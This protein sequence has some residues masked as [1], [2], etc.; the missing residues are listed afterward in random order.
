MWLGI[1]QKEGRTRISIDSLIPQKSQA[2]QCPSVPSV[3]RGCLSHT[4]L[5]KAKCSLAEGWP[6][7]LPLLCSRRERGSSPRCP[8]NRWH[9]ANFQNN[10]CL[11]A[12]AANGDKK[13]AQRSSCSGENIP[14]SYLCRVAICDAASTS[15]RR[16]AV[17]TQCSCKHRVW[18]LLT[19]SI[20][21]STRYSND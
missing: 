6:Q 18:K 10:L 7:L 15:P 21:S 4:R 1:K 17:V 16:K 2:T 20:I 3:W 19:Q 8:G 11:G 5:P 13:G 14:N 9:G 12:R